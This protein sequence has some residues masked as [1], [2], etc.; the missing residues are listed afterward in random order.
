MLHSPLSL[1]VVSQT[2]NKFDGTQNIKI[3]MHLD[4]FCPLTGQIFKEKYLI[5]LLYF[6]YACIS[7]MPVFQENKL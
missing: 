3:V 5:Q 1:L 7:E 4:K 2:V 6:Y